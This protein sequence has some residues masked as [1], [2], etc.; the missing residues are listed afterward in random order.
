MK[1]HISITRNNDKSSY[2]S[3]GGEFGSIIFSNPH[4]NKL[5]PI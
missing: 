2:L 5:N 1:I 4:G 3:M